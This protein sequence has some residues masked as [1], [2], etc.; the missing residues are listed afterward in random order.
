M[1]AQSGAFPLH[2]V[3]VVDLARLDR[4]SGDTAAVAAAA[5]DLAQTAPGD[6]APRSWW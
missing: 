3:R 1:L 6:S 5:R 4:G 2:L